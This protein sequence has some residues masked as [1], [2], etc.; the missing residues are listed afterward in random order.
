MA[1]AKK[2]DK[3]LKKDINIL[4][5]KEKQYTLAKKLFPGHICRHVDIINVYKYCG[6]AQNEEKDI[7]IAFYQRNGYAM[8]EEEINKIKAEFWL[9]VFGKT[10]ENVS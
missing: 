7:K 4:H 2:I 8:P 10:R 3:Y 5:D 6:Y 9:V 1:D